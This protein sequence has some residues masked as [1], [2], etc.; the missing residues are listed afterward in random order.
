MRHQPA[1]KSQINRRPCFLPP[2]L[3]TDI[4]KCHLP[5][6]DILT[7]LSLDITDIRTRRIY[8]RE[9]NSERLADAGRLFA[10]FGEGAPEYDAP[11]NSKLPRQP[12]EP[13]RQKKLWQG[14]GDQPV[15]E[16]NGPR[17]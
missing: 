5:R 9:K 2:T 14:P 1:D 10:G 15:A 6:Q 4:S 16:A 17:R 3:G 13:S 12:S 8:R 11:D 7:C